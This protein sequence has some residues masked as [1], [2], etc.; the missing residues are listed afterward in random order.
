MSSLY[1]ISL[2]ILG[3]NLEQSDQEG[4]VEDFR[5]GD[6]GKVPFS[7]V[8]NRAQQNVAKIGKGRM[9]FKKQRKF[10]RVV[11]GLGKAWEKEG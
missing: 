3:F 5:Q 11:L 9:M 2:G 8:F 7:L 6:V 4:G 1:G 10:L